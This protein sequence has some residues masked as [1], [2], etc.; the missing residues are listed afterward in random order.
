MSPAI[1]LS[2]YILLLQKL[3]R[4]NLRVKKSKKFDL[5]ITKFEFFSFK[6]IIS[7]INF[8]NKITKPK[9][10]NKQIIKGVVI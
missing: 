4:S 1:K 7:L 3:L 8:V 2:H 5:S 9:L 6:F 10:N